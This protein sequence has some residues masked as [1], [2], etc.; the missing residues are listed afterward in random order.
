LAE[1]VE[2]QVQAMVAAGAD[3][4]TVRQLVGEAVRLGRNLAPTHRMEG[5]H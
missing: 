5:S 3:E 4:P 2:G 1:L